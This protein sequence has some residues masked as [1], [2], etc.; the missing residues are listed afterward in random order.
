MR[1][2]SVSFVVLSLGVAARAGAAE[3]PWRGV[4]GQLPE[5]DTERVLVSAEHR[6]LRLDVVQLQQILRAAPLEDTEDASGRQLILALPLPDG[7]FG[8]FRIEESPILEPEL[9]AQFPELRTYRGVGLDDPSAYARFD[10][11]PR[12]LH[13][14]IR[15]VAG[16]VFV[17]PWSRRDT[18]YYISYRKQDYR[19]RTPSDFR[20]LVSGAQ[21]DDSLLGGELRVAF[22]AAPAPA[23]SFGPIKR[24]YRLALAATGEYTG[25]H[26]GQ[27]QAL[28]AIT[29]TL[30]RVN[31]IYEQEA[32]VRMNLIANETAIIYTNA[33][34]DPYSNSDGVAMLC[35]NQC[36]LANVIGSG[37]Y[38]VGHVFSTGG[39]GIAGL[40]VVCSNASVSCA[41]PGAKGRGVTG[42]SK[43]EGDAFDVDYVAHELGH[44]FA[45]NH[46]F[47]GT[48]SACGG[49]NRNAATAY[50]PGSGSTIMA[51]AG[52]CGAQDLQPHSDDYFHT[53]SLDEIE[54]F[55]VSGGGSACDAA[56]VTGNT[57][58]V[59]D[60]GPD[61]TIPKQTPFTLTASVSDV[62]GDPVTV[63]WE[64]LDLGAASP[65][66]TDVSTERPILRSFPPPPDPSRT[67]PKLADVLEPPVN[68]ASEFECLPTRARVMTFRATARDYHA[69]SASGG[70]ASDERNVTITSSG[71]FSV[72]SPAAATTWGMGGIGTVTW[73]VA[74]TSDPPVSCG[75][76][77]IS[78]SSDDGA[79]FPDVLAAATPN[80]GGQAIS[81]PVLGA[82]TGNA[83]VK[84]ACD[85]NIFFNVSARFSVGFTLGISDASPVAEGDSGTTA[86][87]FTVTLSSSLGQ[88]VTVGYA[89]A[90]STATAGSDYNTASGSLTFAP[91]ETMQSVTVEVNGDTTDE[92]DESFVVKLSSATGVAIGD[93][94]GV[95]TI[96]DD[97]PPPLV[98]IGDAS[99]SEGQTGTRA[100]S[101]SVSLSAASGRS[102]S[103]AYATANG[104]ATAGPDYTAA[105]GTLSFS[106]GQTAKIVTVKANGDSQPEGNESFALNLSNPVNVT[107]ADGQGQ[108][109]I[110]DDDAAGSFQFS[111]ASFSASEAA[112]GATISVNRSGGTQ[113]GVSVDW[114]LSSGSAQIG[115]DVSGPSSGTLSFG[116][117]ARLATFKLPIVRD[118]NDEAN[119]T[120]VLRLANP[121]GFMASLGSPS[122]VIVTLLD[123]DTGGKLQF[124]AASIATTENA[125]S[126]LL[127]LRRLGGAAGNVTVDYATTPGTASAADFTATSGTLSF[128]ASQASQTLSIP[129]AADGTAEGSEAF[130]VTLSNP[131]GGGT[132]GSPTTASVTISDD[133]AAFFFS[134]ASY[135]VSE[136]SRNAIVTLKRSGDLSLAATVDYLTS[137]GSATQPGD[138]G[139]AAGVLSFGPR[140]ATKT[141][142]VPIVNDQEIGEGTETV[143]L[144]LQNPFGAT[145]GTQATAVLN[146]SDDDPLQVLQFSSASY[147][148]PEAAQLLLTVKRTAGTV[149]S[150]TVDYASADG[151]ATQPADYAPAAGTLTFGP[152]QLAKTI[153]LVP[154]DD[155]SSEGSESLSFVLTNPSA[156]AVLGANATPSVEII[157]SEPVIAFAA[158]KHA[159]SEAAAKARLTAR[160]TGPLGSSAMVEYA[161]TGGTASATADYNVA[162]SGV[163]TFAAGKA[164]STL[165]LDVVGDTEDEPGETVLLA[166]QNPSP[167]YGLGTPGA[168]SLTINDNDVAGKAQ[169]ALAAVSSREDAGSI[170]I[171]VTRRGGSSSGASVDYT[172]SPGSVNPALPGT[173]YQNVTG[174]LTFAAGEKSKSFSVPVLDDGLA[175]GNHSVTLS[176]TAP[177]GNLTLGNPSTAVLWI[178]D[179]Q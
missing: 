81:V 21:L 31:G 154:A 53:A 100:L 79:S 72:T 11:T 44:Q 54:S 32:A 18:G 43:P 142:L 101:F 68:C 28:A 5:P 93:G 165:Q 36:N 26:G 119:E 167:G 17:D 24:A 136:A 170:E 130:G 35:Q 144:E 56:T 117:G 162:P 61:R 67:F 145:L 138:Y 80:D 33:A 41:C 179:V 77:T 137:D 3:S 7:R 122:T 52:I 73:N 46:T 115:V 84:V 126:A 125:G 4:A 153:A 135:N 34:T 83:R 42:L 66:D 45:A 174:T 148:V 107:I 132:L 112:A 151:S 106:P 90:N 172:T 82:A 176:L 47:N 91:G 58:P 10:W 149:G 19:R 86:A 121:T 114:Q 38:D 104:T 131:G 116:A 62:D 27:S 109:T 178:A 75:S 150:V 155:A 111:A 173:H 133:E 95:G 20:C 96:N 139:A 22:G 129:I 175:S 59:V 76:V 30:N 9:A 103:V 8:R 57:P 29:T 97:D 13:A 88:Q 141:F 166:L 124:A 146:I 163:L 39:G 37:N 134:A 51:Y 128:G 161:I 147:A 48:A 143:N 49:G 25:Y 78:L 15:S 157:D 63:A 156:G 23:A 94:Q 71:P 85:S 123:N 99:V 113:G 65:P 171:T 12:G 87:S 110:L 168:T 92:E 89:T 118:T 105:S 70:T 16:T 1:G 6:T 169:F 160:R 102:V 74:A 159:V 60:A 64:E 50:E 158:A 177:G 120:L 2:V 140:Q 127:T 108:G 164:T 40:G 69:A 55:V 14:M 152:G 98:S